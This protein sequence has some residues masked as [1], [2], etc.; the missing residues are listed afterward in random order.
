MEAVDIIDCI[1]AYSANH[2]LHDEAEE[3]TV[4]DNL[5]HDP[6]M[7]DII[8][9]QPEF[10]AKN[11]IFKQKPIKGEGDDI[12]TSEVEGH[13]PT[14]KPAQSTDGA[15][16]E[17]AN[18]E[19]NVFIKK[20]K[21][22]HFKL[23][24]FA[25]LTESEVRSL[26]DIIACIKSETGDRRIA[27][28]LDLDVSALELLM[29]AINPLAL[30]NLD[31]KIHNSNELGRDQGADITT[32]LRQLTR[33][34][35]AEVTTKPDIAADMVG[36]FPEDVTAASRFLCFAGKT[37][38]FEYALVQRY[39]DGVK[40]NIYT[41]P[42]SGVTYECTRKM[43]KLIGIPVENILPFTS[44]D[45]IDPNKQ[46]EIAQRL[47]EMNFTAA[48][49]NPPYQEHDG[50]AGESSRPLYNHF[51]TAL[52]GFPLPYY[53]MIMPSRWMSGGKGLDEFRGQMLDDARIRELHDFLHPETVFPYT[54]NRG[55]VCYFLRDKKYDNVVHLP[56]V[57]THY[58]E[59]DIYPCRRPLK[60]EDM[61]I[62]FRN[63]RAVSIMEKVESRGD[64]T[65]SD[66]ISAAKAFGLRTYF[67]KDPRFKQSPKECTFPIKCYGNKG[68]IGYVE[69]AVITSHKEWV[70]RWK[71]YVPE[72]NNI[73]TELRDDNQNT[74]VGAPETVC[75]E[76]FLVVGANLNLT[77]QSA[78][79][80][81]DYL[82]TRF[83]RF[84]L[85][86]AKNS[87]HGTSATYRFV[88]LQDFSRPWTDADLYEKYHL[89]P[90]E[91]QFIESMIKPMQMEVHQE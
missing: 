28:H 49:G 6:M 67:V 32:A 31:D 9:N 12:D 55:G 68:K 77:Q 91:I 41:I 11:G 50:G 74:I 90:E 80:L 63:S 79:N 42:T 73:G 22:L 16:T 29:A 43:F 53:V 65:L 26:A 25:Y 5:F 60:L 7:L 76:S 30:S 20:L 35:A 51:V 48:I 39:G 75:T 40:K 44:F 45:I 59:H 34:S 23:L 66:Y 64:G 10:G 14:A 70:N 71:V 8:A 17:Q 56:K 69:K 15:S 58:S 2:S 85:S 89:L 78:Q 86:L 84:M 13:A 81:S 54:N 87:Q 72:S 27:Y 19:K 61:D 21:T 38:E 57:V 33:L 52:N 88:P 36:L 18:D 1:R 62:F 24:L 4:D 46:Q 82:R 37:G 83:A 3:V 47:M